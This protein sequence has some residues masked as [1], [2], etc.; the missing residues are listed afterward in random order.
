MDRNPLQRYN[1]L[2]LDVDVSVEEIMRYARA[3]Y[4]RVLYP[5]TPTTRDYRQ[6]RVNIHIDYERIIQ[7]V[8]MY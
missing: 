6:D 1:G 7:K 3:V 4:V 2:K 5:D 8:D